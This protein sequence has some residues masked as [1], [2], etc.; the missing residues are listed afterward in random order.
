M[1]AQLRG[2][3]QWTLAVVINSLRQGMRDEGAVGGGSQPR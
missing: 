1:T 2:R 3:S